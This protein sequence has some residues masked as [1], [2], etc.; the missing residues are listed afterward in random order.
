MGTFAGF[1]MS[2]F[3]VLSGFVI[4]Y[5]YSKL[6]TE[7]GP[8]GYLKFMWA[9]FSRLYPMF[10]FVLLA[11][12]FINS[13]VMVSSMDALEAFRALPWFILFMQSWFYEIIGSNSLIYQIGW[14][15]PLTW[16]ISTEWFFYIT[17]LLLAYPIVSVSRNRHWAEVR[18]VAV[19]FAWIVIFW[20]AA[21]LVFDQR[22]IIDKWAFQK[23]GLIA[24]QKN[25]N[26][27]SFVRWVLYF[28]PYARIGEFVTG[29][30]VC[31]LYLS[32]KDKSVTRREGKIGLLLTWGALMTIPVCLFLMHTPT[33]IF[34]GIRKVSDNIGLAPFI[35]VLI[36]CIAR[37]KNVIS[38]FLA[39]RPIISM[40]EASYSIYLIHMLVF[41]WITRAVSGAYLPMTVAGIIFGLA[42]F[43]LILS[44][45][46]ILSLGLYAI[47]E[48]PAR[49]WLRSLWR[50]NA[51]IQWRVIG[52]LLAPLCMAGMI[53][54]GLNW[55]GKGGGYDPEIIIRSATYGA[56]CGAVEGNVTQ[57]IQSECSKGE[58]CEYT[59]DFK[60]LGDTA[61]GCGKDYR[62]KYSC[63]NGIIRSA[64]I[65]PGEA[66]LGSRIT[67]DC[68]RK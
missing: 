51:A 43:V 25:G 58:T 7:Q 60:K 16:S 65:V 14:N 30:L 33:P 53:F 63:K 32:V 46:I 45:L 9:R 52:I 24:T 67:L 38:K 17:Y 8:S 28:S 18:I 44:F 42:R 50:E 57:H 36:F 6:V 55:F 41:V 47:L 13:K 19:I 68:S 11:D 26:Q 2:L 31:G 5:N 12:Y 48:V 35:A 39:W 27:D 20:I 66:G 59:I 34:Y 23:F 64:I 54:L 37:Y 56:N 29:C 62:V 61:P 15:L 49:T 3:F 1:G 21:A 40:G 10:L 22:E 4:H